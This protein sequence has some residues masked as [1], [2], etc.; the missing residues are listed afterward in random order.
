MTIDKIPDIKEIDSANNIDELRLKE[1]ELSKIAWE[2]LK[3]YLPKD[4][5]GRKPRNEDPINRSIDYLYSLIYALCTHALISVG[6]DPFYGFMH[7]N[8]PGKYALTYDFS[9]MFKPFAIH[10]LLTTI[11]RG[12]SITLDKKNYLTS[13]SLTIF[14]KNFYEMLLKR[15]IRAIIYLK[16]NELKKS[17]VEY[18]AFNPYVYKPG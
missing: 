10:V 16:A 1:A 3:K 5:S 13:F 11:R 6:L 14:T 4:F 8:G 15:K 7:T 17:I 2:E 9:E 12:T 18:K